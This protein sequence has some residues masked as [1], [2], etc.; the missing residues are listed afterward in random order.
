MRRQLVLLALLLG[1]HAQAEESINYLIHQHYVS[2]RALGAG[3]SFMVIDDYNTL[4]YN[5]AG[6]ARLPE[7]T[8]NLGFSAAITSEVMGFAKDIENAS[9][10]PEATKVQKV[11]ELLEKNY[12]KT[13]GTRLPAVNAIWTRPRWGI[14]LILLDTQVNLGVHQVVGPQLAVDAYADN[15]LA[16]GYAKGYLE[17]QALTVGGTLKAIYRGYVGKSFSALDVA[18]D[19]AFFKAK[20]AQEGLTIDA[21]LGTQYVMK[22][23]ESG[24]FSFLKHAKPTFGLVVRNI[25]DYGFQQNLKLVDKNSSGKPPKLGRRFDI[26][27]K[28]ELPEFWV[29]KPRFMFDV[30]D[31]GHKYFT[32]LKGLH[33]GFELQWNATSWLLGHYSVGLGQGY[34]SAGV[35]AQLAWFRLDLATFGEELGTSKAKKENRYYMA[36]M[37]LDF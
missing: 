5:P 32:F 30:R 8:I 24:F 1:T 4:F 11:S 15:T 2:P 29:F 7:G 10:E 27:S 21:D 14:G 18:A 17:D 12:G 23:P 36:K 26:G 20:D 9:K 33:T 6:L 3:N 25:A 37:S 22:V 19:P 13:Y 31:I 16:F 35:G 28:F 34:L